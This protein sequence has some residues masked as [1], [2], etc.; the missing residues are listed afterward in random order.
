MVFTSVQFIFVRISDV[1]LTQNILVNK[2]VVKK[3]YKMVKTSVRLR[4]IQI[5][6][7]PKPQRFS[8]V[9]RRRLK[10]EQF[11]NGT[12]CRA[13]KIRPFGFRTLTVTANLLMLSTLSTSYLFGLLHSICE[14]LISQVRVV[15][16]PLNA[17]ARAALSVA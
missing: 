12:Y 9:F 6:D 13:S 17:K 15:E 14:T 8:S 10:S 2:R 4:Q 3:I 1:G 5:S 16:T 7:S 11:G